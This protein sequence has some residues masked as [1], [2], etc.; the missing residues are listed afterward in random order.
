MAEITASMIKELR[1]RTQAGMLDCKKALT[2]C[3]GDMEKAAE[4]LRKKGLA[5]ANKRA[6]R[7]AK[8]GLVFVKLSDDGKKGSIVE[9]NCETDF[10]A[11][12]EEFHNL[13]NKITS[14]IFDNSL[15][16]GAEIPAALDETIKGAIATTGE[17]M[18]IGSFDTIEIDKGAIASYIHSNGKIGVLVAL[19]SDASDSAILCELGRELAMQAAAAFPQYVTSDEVPE[20]VKDKEREIYK[21]QM[22]NSGK[23][24]NI[25]DKIVEGKLSK[26][27]SDVCL[28]DQVFIKDSAKKV[29]DV[30]KEY[31]TKAGSPI[32]IEKFIRVQIGG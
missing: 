25:I 30:V 4:F 32:K 1:E 15:K 22:K 23:P 6:G 17:N 27:Y 11:K 14:E 31:S 9:L 29:S 21:E 8:E 12:N 7:E 18:G 26:F 5:A 20:T 16:S 3:D 24:E 2:E 13:G 19:A 28:V 10:V